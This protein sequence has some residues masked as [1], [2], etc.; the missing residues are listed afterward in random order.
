MLWLLKFWSRSLFWWIT[1]GCS[2]Q[3]PVFRSPGASNTFNNH[4]PEI[5]ELK[6]SEFKNLKRPMTVF[7]INLIHEIVS[8]INWINSNPTSLDTFCFWW[9]FLR[10]SRCWICKH[11]LIN[12]FWELESKTFFVEVSSSWLPTLTSYK[13]II[14]Y[15]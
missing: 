10:W 9:G 15:I 1:R 6:Q 4:Q 8:C 14:K 11:L 3:R 12:Y 7:L 13:S 2:N 5:L